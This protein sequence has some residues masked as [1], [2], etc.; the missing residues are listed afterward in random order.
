LEIPDVELE[1]AN[2][3]KN[4]RIHLA[5]SCVRF[6]LFWF[7]SSGNFC[8][9]GAICSRGIPIRIRTTSFKGCRIG[10]DI[11]MV[12]RIAGV[13][14]LRRRVWGARHWRETVDYRCRVALPRNLPL[15]SCLRQMAAANEQIGIAKAAYYPTLNIAATVGL[16]G[17]GLEGNSGAELVSVA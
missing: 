2:R 11:G 1:A 6:Y 16:E 13:P 8:D 5:L 10:Q 17:V 9:S 7:K 15:S 12:P 3:P 14:R 4:I